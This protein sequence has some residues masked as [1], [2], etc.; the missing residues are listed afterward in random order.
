[1][2]VVTRAIGKEKDIKG[3]K[4]GKQKVKLFLFAN[5]ILYIYK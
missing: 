5:N 3:T 2:E 1:L 4:V